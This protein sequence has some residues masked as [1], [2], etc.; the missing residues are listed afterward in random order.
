ML[1]QV[2]NLQFTV[3]CQSLRFYGRVLQVNFLSNNT[4]CY[5]F[6]SF[7][8]TGQSENCISMPKLTYR[9]QKSFDKQS[10]AFISSFVAFRLVLFHFCPHP[11]SNNTRMGAIKSCASTTATTNKLLFLCRIGREYGKTNLSL[12]KPEIKCEEEKQL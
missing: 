8:S 10:S 4:T 12:C 7:R 9:M 2:I 11:A 1:L 3:S 5:E 6:K